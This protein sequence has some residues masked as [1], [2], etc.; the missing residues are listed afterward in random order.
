MEKRIIIETVKP[1]ING[2]LFPVKR[3]VGEKLKVISH[4]YSDGYD[5]ISAQVVYKRKAEKKWNFIPMTP[6]GN[7]VWE[8]EFK[9]KE[10]KE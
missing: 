6:L 2:G 9:V 10:N 1:E 5:L 3:I 7:D 4:I 8:A